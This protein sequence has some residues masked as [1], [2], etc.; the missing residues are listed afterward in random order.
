MKKFTLIALCLLVASFVSAQQKVN[1]NYVSA[2]SSSHY[3]DFDPAQGLNSRANISVVILTPDGLDATTYVSTQ[4]STFTDLTVTTISLADIA[5]LT[6]ADISSYQVCFAFNDKT[7]ES[8]GTTRANVGNVLGQYIDGGGKVI[9]SMF[10]K[11]YDNWGLA[12]TYITGN[13]SAFG[14]T[15]ADSWDETSTMGTVHAPAHP[16][17]TGVTSLEQYFDTQDP[18]LAA[19]A[20]QIVDWN[21]GDMAIAAKTDVV[22]FNMLPCEPDG[23]PTIGGDAWIAIHNAIVWM[24]DDHSGIQEESNLKI[25]T[26]PN[27]AKDQLFIRTNVNEG[28]VTITNVLGEIICQQQ[29][30]SNLTEINTDN[31]NSGLYFVRIESANKV[32]TSKFIV[33]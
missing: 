15:S 21:N 6:L 18:T 10:L 25:S 4:L 30:N 12:G 23:N 26:Y 7:W 31:Y 13:Y 1:P 33:E 9:E 24:A 32:T 28:I 20:T 29:L 8:G 2:T 22:S 27:P 3:S 5:T 11:S 16:I 19:G 14:T 17:M